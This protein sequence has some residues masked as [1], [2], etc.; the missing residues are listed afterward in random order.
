M[1]KFIFYGD[2]PSYEDVLKR[3]WVFPIILVIFSALSLF[4]YFGYLFG[5]IC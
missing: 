2:E 4:G 1:E 5:F 3:Y